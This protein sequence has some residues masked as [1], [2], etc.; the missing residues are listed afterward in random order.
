MASTERRDRNGPNRKTGG[1][2]WKEWNQYG[3]WEEQASTMEVELGGTPGHCSNSC[4]GE[5]KV[6]RRSFIFRRDSYPLSLKFY[7]GGEF[8]P[9]EE[10][11][12]TNLIE[13]NLRHLLRI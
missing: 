3:G 10:R 9:H 11:C 13:L 12:G 8:C 7:K 4:S 1:F 6:R 5:V 2:S